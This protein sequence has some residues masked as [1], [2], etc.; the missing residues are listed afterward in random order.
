MLL[1]H[2]NRQHAVFNSKATAMDWNQ[3][4]ED[5]QNYK[6][7]FKRRWRK[8]SNVDVVTGQRER[9]AVSIQE[10]YGISNE[11]AQKQITEW[12]SRETGVV[13]RA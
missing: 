13:C 5:W 6:G 8:L 11:E 12:L 7:S 2:E 3:I 10:K 1:A 9:L 4:E